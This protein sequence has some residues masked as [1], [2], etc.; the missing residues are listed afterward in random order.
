MKFWPRYIGAWR[1]KT[2]I[3]NAEEKG[4]YCE[5]LDEHYASELPLPL[6]LEARCR[7]AGAFKKTEQAAVERICERFFIK[8]EEG[9]THERA[10]EEIAK[11]RVISG[12]RSAAAVIKWELE[13]AKEK[14]VK[15]KGNGQGAVALPDWL[16][17]QIWA[18]W[19]K[20]RPGRAR[21]PAAQR[22]ALDKLDAFR[23]AGH[24]PSAIVAES[25]ANGW[26]GLF[27]PKAGKAARV[28]PFNPGPGRPVM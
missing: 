4:I 19:L 5:L 27:E 16:N 13:R 25:L 11:Y 8:G 7:I 3:L 9:Y 17:A 21:T 22:A 10:A 24:D 15:S 1:A 14:P 23:Q 6:E 28:D 2:A 26:Q 20:S 12:K 18:D